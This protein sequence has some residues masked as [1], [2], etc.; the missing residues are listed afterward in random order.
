MINLY[1]SFFYVFLF[2]VFLSTL[3]LNSIS[4]QIYSR[5]FLICILLENK[6]VKL[7]DQLGLE[8]LQTTKQKAINSDLNLTVEDLNRNITSL[9]NELQQVQ[10]SLEQTDKAVSYTHLTLPTNREV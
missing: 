4:F 6:I 7:V 3:R 1:D 10:K 9:N 8:K 2:Y 5:I